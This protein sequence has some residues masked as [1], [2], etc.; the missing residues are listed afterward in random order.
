MEK[1]QILIAEDDGI[2]A[3]D[4]ENRMKQLGYGVTGIVGY[5]EQAIEKVKEN[6]PDVVLMDIILKG[7]IDGID[8]AEKIRTQ[9]DIPVIFIT[10]YADKDRL[11]RAKL[12]YPFGFIIK[13]FQDKDLEVT[14]EMALYVAKVDAERKKVEE[15][16][17]IH[18]IELESQNE[19]LRRSQLELEA[20]RDRY[21]DLYDF[22]PVGYITISE[23]GLILEANLTV[24]TMLGEEKSSMIGKSLSRFI[25]SDTQDVFYLHLKKLL[26]TKS[27]QTCE[28][29]LKKKDD[30]RF[31]AQLEAILIEDA[32]G[33]INQTR[34]VVTDVSERVQIGKEKKNLE[35]Q[36]RQSSKMEAIGTLAGGMAHD[37]NNIL[38][39]ILGN[40]EL[41]MDD[42]PDSNPA[43]LNLYEA[44]TAC[45]RAKDV[46]RN[47]LSFA[48]K[49][50]LRKK[51]VRLIPIVRETMRLLRASIPTSIEIRQ[52]IPDTSDIILAD[53]T[54]INQLVLNLC[55]NAAHAMPDGGVMEISL[56]NV[57]FDQDTTIQYHKLTPGRYVKLTVSDTGHGIKPEIKDRIF[58]PYFTTKGVDEG[59]GLGLSVVHGIVKNNDGAISA[60]S[61]FGKGTKGSRKNKFTFLKVLKCSS[62][63]AIFHV[64]R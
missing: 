39:I 62:N 43:R 56:K 2:I 53:S 64:F 47:L 19:E 42:V 13:P 10:G 33:N 3:M 8:A 59:S 7:E 61:E 45:L 50:E 26:E 28:L 58:D 1:A 38:S 60:E 18:Q 40:T 54:Q 51:P 9:Y 20:A 32:D 12:T 17:R 48:H 23:K 31:Y 52:I 30:T 46:I 24:T 22:A 29:R 63:L 36:I 14:I 44:H 35:S 6:T 55:T 34:I 41:A 57:E 49:A 27:K 37:F 15:D 5:G 16:L 25:T 11:E 21:S 4:L